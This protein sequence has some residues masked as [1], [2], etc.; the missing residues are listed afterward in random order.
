MMRLATG[1]DYTGK[2]YPVNPSHDEICGLP[3]YASLY[4]LPDTVDLVVLCLANERLEAHMDIVIE[5]GVPAMAFFASGNLDEDTDP[6]LLSRLKEKARRAG[7]HICGGNGMGFCNYDYGLIV[8][9]A[10]IREKSP[11]GCVT[12]IAQSGS[13]YAILLQNQDNLRTNLAISCGNEI[14][15]SVAD[16]MDFALE[17]PSTKVVGIFLEAVRDP[18]GFLQALKKAAERRIPVVILKTGRTELAA[19]IAQSHTG[20]VVGDSGVFEALCKRYGA[21]LVRC[22]DE[23]SAT[24][25][26]LQ[27]DFDFGDGGLACITDSGGLNELTADLA[28]DIG[29]DFVELEPA[30]IQRLANCLET[31]LEPMNPLDAWGTY[32]GFADRYRQYYDIFLEDPNVGLMIHLANF[33]DIG[34][35]YAD[36]VQIACERKKMHSTP[37]A[38]VS[39]YTRS[40]NNIRTGE[41]AAVGIPMLDG[42][43][44]GLVAA[45]NALAYRDFQTAREVSVSD[46]T[47]VDDAVRQKW[48]DRL[49]E[50]EVLGE[51]DAL[52][53]LQDYG[54]PVPRFQVVEQRDDVAA[55]ARDIGYPVVLKTAKPG[56]HHK[57]DVGGVVL[58]I[59]N[60]AALL[61]AYDDMCARLGDKAI[62]C[63]CVDA[64]VEMGLGAVNDPQFGPFVM[65]SAG[66]ILIEIMN[67]STLEMAPFGRDAA[68]KSI[69]RLKA[70]KLLDGVRGKAPADR[71]ALADM[72]SRLSIVADDLKDQFGEIDVNPVIVNEQGAVAVDALVFRKNAVQNQ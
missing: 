70:N 33:D 25:L 72:M 29:L 65:I 68:T 34:F 17:Q 26:L 45:K 54:I 53:L 20:A 4:D 58:N 13:A 31:G 42:M 66:G 41:A 37:I 57:T 24:L 44:F 61:T 10:P 22:I 16:Y 55:T 52:M 32:G 8:C 40:K 14:A 27:E 21:I 38:L 36:F 1:G 46:I 49:A 12:I 11:D 48:R 69:A 6:P 18:A 50:V 43:H 3:C 30:S 39:A 9:M 63:Q 5:L 51:I 15:T 71:A 59:D 28:D 67:D 7:L 62:I 23:W 64:G 47:A 56:V 60:E 35:L 2:I 19:E